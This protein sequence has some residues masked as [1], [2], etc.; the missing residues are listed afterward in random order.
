MVTS[1]Q[2]DCL[3][4]R[5]RSRST[6]QD[7]SPGRAEPRRGSSGRTGLYGVAWIPGGRDVVLSIGDDRNSA[8]LY[9][10]SP[11]DSQGTPQLLNLAERG[12]IQPEI[13]RSNQRLIYARS[14]LD[15]D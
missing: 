7:F 1:W 9:R 6:V 13:S 2:V 12:A 14:F 4:A 5:E 10:V 8:S 11:F 3:Y 15:N